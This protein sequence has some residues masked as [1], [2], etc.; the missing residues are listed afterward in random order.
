[1]FILIVSRGYPSDKYKMNGIFE[2]DQ[3]KALV[4]QGH[5]VVYCAIDLRSIRRSRRWGFESFEKNGVLIEAINIPCG[6]IPKFIFHNI[7]KL[8]LRKLYKKIEKKFGKPDIIHAHF[9]NSGFTVAQVCSD[10]KIPLVLTEHS[11]LMNQKVLSPY[12]LKLGRETYFCMDKII[13]VSKHLADNIKEKFGVKLV[14][15]PNIVDTESFKYQTKINND[16]FSFVSTGNL[17]KNK[18]M[19]ILIEAFYKAFNN[20][21][22]VRLYIYGNGPEY[23]Y[24]MQMIQNYKLKD[25]VF[26]MGLV[27][28]KEIAKKMSESDCFVLASRL[29]TFGVAYIEAMSM[30]L[31]VIAT[32]CGGP[33]DFVTK[34]NGIL[35]PIDNVDAL[36]NALCSIYKNIDYYDRDKISDSAKKKFGAQTIANKLIELYGDL[37]DENI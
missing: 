28:R 22:K 32:K 17:L 37:L 6:R 14:I 13:T 29:E 5:K 18:R 23:S 34:E 1:M 24:L 10:L 7:G 4:Q 20:N 31:P 2:F 19:D 27:E 30:G 26:L 9:I 25:Q 12:L 36:S 21:K 35:L 8:G 16:L 15:I 11:S 3:A 33:E